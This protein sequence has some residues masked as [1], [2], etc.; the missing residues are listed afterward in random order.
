M[1]K[2]ILRTLYISISKVLR[3][4]PLKRV[5][6]ISTIHDWLYEHLARTKQVKLAGFTLNTDPRDRTIAKKLALY[7]DYEGYMREVLLSY[8]K[9]GS[10]VIDIGANIGLHTVPL[11]KGVGDGGK[12]IAFEPDPDNYAILQSNL[13]INNANNVTTHNAGLSSESGTALLYQSDINRGGLSLC[14][15][16]VESDGDS[17]QPVSIDLLVGD[18]VLQDY[19]ANIS[20]IKI[21]VEGAEPLVIKGMKNVLASNPSLTIVFEFSPIYIENFGQDPKVFLSSLE[22]SGFNLSIVDEQ[23]QTTKPSSSDQGCNSLWK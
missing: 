12:V 20:L 22:E 5:A 21:D 19:S 3:K 17:I 2:S 9:P 6:W 10:T 23:N 7:G 1:I 8:T 14:K 16:N 18:D 11:S 15:D 13:K 4:T